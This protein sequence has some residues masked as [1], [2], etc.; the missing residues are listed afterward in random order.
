LQAIDLSVSPDQRTALRI[1]T[2]GSGNRFYREDSLRER[3]YYLDLSVGLSRVYVVDVSGPSPGAPL[4]L[5]RAP[6]LGRFGFSD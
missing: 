6:S 5:L 2:A 1:D 4:E 3:V